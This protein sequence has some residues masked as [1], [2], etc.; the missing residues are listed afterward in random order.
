VKGAAAAAAASKNTL[1]L[2]TS[3]GCKRLTQP[4]TLRC[5]DDSIIPAGLLLLR[6]IVVRVGEFI[7][8]GRGG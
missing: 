1:P 7:S 8:A 2:H 3:R 4:V 6:R 5:R